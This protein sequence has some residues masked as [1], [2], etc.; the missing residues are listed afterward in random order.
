MLASAWERVH[1]EIFCCREKVGNEK[2][3]NDKMLLNAQ[4]VAPFATQAPDLQTS[5]ETGFEYLMFRTVMHI[6]SQQTCNARLRLCVF[7]F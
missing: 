2:V 4:I 7:S 5:Q 3:E 6:T 1:G